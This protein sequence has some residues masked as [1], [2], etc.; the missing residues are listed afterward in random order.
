MTTPLFSRRNGRRP[1][2]DGHVADRATPTRAPKDEGRTT[3]VVR[4]SFGQQASGAH[5]APAQRQGMKFSTSGSGPAIGTSKN[6]P[7]PSGSITRV[8]LLAKN[9]AICCCA[10]MA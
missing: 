4:P 6:G 8:P 10:P 3:C 1:P 2:I 7:G 9:A 5:A